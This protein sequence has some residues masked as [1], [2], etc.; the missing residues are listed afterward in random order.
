MSETKKQEKLVVVLRESVIASLIKDA[1]T[2][3]LF[4]GL[5]WFNHQYL[6]GNG[7]LDAIFVI[8]V[9]I[10]LS[11]LNLSTVY[12]GNIEGAIKWLGDKK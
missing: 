6:D 4:G 9:I 12:K 8:I 1:G 7:W 10:W 11:S 3:L 2:F 5:L